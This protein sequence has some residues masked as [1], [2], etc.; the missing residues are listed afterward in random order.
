MPAPKGNKN[1]TKL[2][3]PEI[4]QEAFKQYCEWIGK[5]E[6]KEAFVFDHPTHSVCF[7][8]M[9]RYI[10]ENP[11][12]FP[13]IHREIADARGY[14]HWLELGKRMMLGDIKGSQPAIY[15]MFMRNK[16]GW[17]KAESSKEESP[18]EFDQQLEV[19][20]PLS[21]KEPQKL[22]VTNNS[23]WA[24]RIKDE[25]APIFPDLEPLKPVDCDERI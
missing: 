1:G 2:K 16:F 21:R 6:S 14:G 3:D 10:R 7:K 19:I 17:D 20:K 23:G 4:R 25:C 8:T 12:E 18:I 11:V 15:Q 9:E 13:P 24:D 22:F 5:G